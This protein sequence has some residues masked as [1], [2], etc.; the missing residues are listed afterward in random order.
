MCVCIDGIEAGIMDDGDE[1]AMLAE[2]DAELGIAP[3]D[4]HVK[5][6]ELQG[7]VD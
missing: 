7:Q 1:A 5:A 4:P 6:S 2:L 3:M